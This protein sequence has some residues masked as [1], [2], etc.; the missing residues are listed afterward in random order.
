MY[1]LLAPLALSLLLALGGPRAAGAQEAVDLELL[2]A[3][4]ASSSVDREEFALQMQGLAEAFRAP[5][6]ISAIRAAG[7]RGIAVALLQWSGERRQ[8]LSV[9]WTRVA[10]AAGARAFADR[11]AGTAREVLSGGTAIGTALEVAARE[12]ADNA[13]AGAR[14][15]ID[16]SGDGR[17]NMGIRPSVRRDDAVAQGITINALALLNEEPGLDRYYLERVIGGTGAFV[18]TAADYQAFAEAIR[19]K[20]V[21]EISGTPVAAAPNPPPP[22]PRTAQAS[23]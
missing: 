17:A 9:P 5:A 15:V 1:R 10:D 12:L 22:G 7:D 18:M 6:V 13:Y 20:L 19:R 11:I 2:L 23:P 14:R 16:L 21:R 8:I 3:V 4:D